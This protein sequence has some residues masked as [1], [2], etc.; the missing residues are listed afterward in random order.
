MINTAKKSNDSIHIRSMK[1]QDWTDVA[2][3]YSLGIQ[4]G[5]AT[6]EQKVP[7]WESWDQSHLKTC[8]LLA[9]YK[10]EVAGWAALTGVTGRCVYAG[11]AEVSI[12]V[13]PAFQGRKIGTYL[14]KKLIEESESNNIWTLEAGIFPENKASI[15]LH[16]AAG[17]RMVGYRERIGQMNGHWKDIILLERRS[18]IIGQ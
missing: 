11:V 13:D 10:D 1:E 2:R 5:H 4:S 17:F 15:K 7:E 14:L 6:F 12:Y 18:K 8:R 9:E 16:E 3:I